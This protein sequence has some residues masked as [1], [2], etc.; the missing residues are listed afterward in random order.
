MID[1]SNNTE[2]ARPNQDDKSYTDRNVRGDLAS[3][4]VIAKVSIC[5]S[6]KTCS[7]V[8]PSI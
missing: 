4:V 2:V 5:A 6:E 8:M 1:E 3:R 7:I